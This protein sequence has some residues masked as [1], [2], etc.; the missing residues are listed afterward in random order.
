VSQVLRLRPSEI[1]P[2]P[3]GIGGAA[4]E[5]IAGIGRDRGRMV[6]LLDLGAVLGGAGVAEAVA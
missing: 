3:Q 6:I 4:A 5:Y 1:E 2:R